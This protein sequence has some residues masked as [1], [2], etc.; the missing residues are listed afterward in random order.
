[1]IVQRLKDQDR[2]LL[3][4]LYNTQTQRNSQDIDRFFKKEFK[5]SE[6]LVYK[7]SGVILCAM[8]VVDFDFYFRGYSIES[9]IIKDLVVSKNCPK[10]VF[11][12][13]VNQTLESF[14]YLKLLTFSDSNFIE[15]FGFE[16]PIVLKK[17]KLFRKDLFNVDGYSIEKAE[18]E[19]VLAMSS[20]YQMF[21]KNFK[22]YAIKDVNVFE[23]LIDKAE[24]KFQDIHVT[25]N[26]K[27]DMMGYIVYENRNNQISVLEIIY[28]DTIALL[29]LLNQAM[30]MSDSISINVSLKE[31]FSKI[32]KKIEYE[33]IEC[34]GIMINDEELFQR[35]YNVKETSLSRLIKDSNEPYYLGI[36]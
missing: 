33:T 4:S 5:A 10:L 36:Y 6:F 8:R 22:S 14:K 18:Y 35:L 25:Y 20:C 34:V 11:Q 24:D 12:S 15:T 9:N 23:E 1:M 26:Q 17:Y 2:D 29:T 31:N 3:Y 32:F 28:R 16:S 7:E 21:T 13:F 30:G 19:D 27:G